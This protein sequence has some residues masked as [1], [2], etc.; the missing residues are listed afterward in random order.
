[1]S[2][3]ICSCR[4]WRENVPHRVRASL[5]SSRSCPSGCFSR[6]TTV[7]SSTVSR[8][9]KSSTRM[10]LADSYTA[11]RLLRASDGVS[12]TTLPIVSSS[13][14]L[15]MSACTMVVRWSLAA[16]S[17]A[18]LTMFAS[19]APVNPVVANAISFRSTSAPTGLEATCTLRISSL[20]SASGGPIT[21]L[22]SNRP[23][24][25]RAG[26]RTSGRFVA[27]MTTMLEVS[28]KPSSSESIWLSVWSRS[29]L[30]PPPPPRLRPTASSSSMNTIAGADLR[31]CANRSR[32]RAAPTPTN[33][34]TNSD[35]V[36]EKK[37]T[38][39]SPA[40]ARAS[41]VFPVPGGPHNKTPRGMR[42]PLA[43]YFSG[44]LKKST[45]SI[46][47]TLASP[48]PATSSN[49]TRLS[50]FPPVLLRPVR[51]VSDTCAFVR[52]NS[53]ASSRA[54]FTAWSSSFNSP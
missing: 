24:R 47:S 12:S 36:M 17:A 8:E 19:A 4:Y 9:G 15:N 2:A 14:A 25:I 39:D 31:A 16:T 23:G 48:I 1:M 53:L 51:P 33:I 13:S 26:S 3:T 30:P 46:S 11:R 40:T 18:R 28:E 6:G 42:L 7:T 10:A 43:L 34:S 35:A 27:A 37:A 20:P 49:V 38:P 50:S 21:T 29:S 45:T 54:W 5:N 44:F 22:R 41:S 32:T 52:M